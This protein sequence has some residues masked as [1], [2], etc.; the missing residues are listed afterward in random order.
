MINTYDLQLDPDDPRFVDPDFTD[1]TLIGERRELAELIRL[2]TL[3]FSWSATGIDQFIPD[4]F[5]QASVDLSDSITWEGIDDPRPLTADDLA[6]DVLAAG[7]ERA[8]TVP[9]LLLNEPML[10]SDGENSDIRYNAFFP[11]WAY[12]R[13]HDLLLATAEAEDWQLLDLWDALPTDAFTDSPVHTTGA[14][15]KVVADALITAMSE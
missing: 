6:F 7:I 9:V 3:G 1:Q 8:G 5:Q 15:A 14:G 4:T 2:Q 13:Y 11:R 12:D 10:V